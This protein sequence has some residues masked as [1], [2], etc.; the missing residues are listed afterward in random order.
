MG[1]FAA[2]ILLSV[3]V[4]VGSLANGPVVAA[5]PHP[6]VVP[7]RY[8]VVLHDGVDPI[9]FARGKAVVPDVVFE[10]ALNGFSTALSARQ[11]AALKIDARVS[12]IEQEQV[13]HTTQELPSG[14]NRID[15]E[16]NLAAAI[17]GDGGDL[18]VDIAIIDT[19]IDLTHPDL[20]VV[21]GAD[22]SRN[23]FLCKS[24]SAND[25]NGHGTHVAGTAAAKDNI[26]GVVGVAPGARLW[27]VKVLTDSG[28]GYT[29]CVIKGVDYVTANAASIEVA[30]MSLGGGNSI[31]LCDAIKR[32]VA[33]GVVYAVA[34][35]NSAANAS[36]ASPANCSAV[37]TGVLTVSAVA[38]YNGKGGG[39]GSATCANYGAD[40]SLASFSNF[41]SVVNI[42]APGVCIKSTWKGGGYNTISGTS[43][44]SPHVA[45]AAALYILTS[46]I[47]PGNLTQ[48]TA[49]R[50]ALI[51]GGKVEGSC[52]F[53][54]GG[55]DG[56]N[57]PMLYVGISGLCN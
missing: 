27:P 52:G 43:M 40:D 13:F 26:S 36:N 2:I 49:V 24:K 32:S 37:S 42:A 45:G 11:L 39:G 4:G 50:D 56:F 29:S 6:G 20:R 47:N 21:K 5:P 8:I 53:T 16:Q 51:A 46:G 22:F 25:G 41:G 54:G 30:N 18:D 7:G 23:A 12:Y 1:R 14:V 17:A 57:E 44:A 10:H 3:V 38:D 31:A 35:G 28:S 48:A 9:A 34:A 15:G 33:L 19:G 55:A